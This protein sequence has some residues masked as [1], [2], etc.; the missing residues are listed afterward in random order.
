MYQSILRIR[1]KRRRIG[2]LSRGGSVGATPDSRWIVCP[3]AEGKCE[4][5]ARN[6]VDYASKLCARDCLAKSCPYGG[7][8]GKAYNWFWQEK[9]A[10]AGEVLELDAGKARGK[11]RWVSCRC[12]AVL[13]K[14][15][16]IHLF[17]PGFGSTSYW[18][19]AGG[20]KRLDWDYWKITAKIGLIGIETR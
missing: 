8:C 18:R 11:T 7:N 3:Y 14:V 4:T 6:P 5:S 16:H 17:L 1:N 2:W 15:A 13:Q 20:V 10:R 12:S 19:L 9:V